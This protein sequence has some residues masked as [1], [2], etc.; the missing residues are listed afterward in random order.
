M[1]PNS[2]VKKFLKYYQ[3]GIGFIAILTLGTIFYFWKLGFIDGSRSSTLYKANFIYNGL[4]EKSHFVEVA[5]LVEREKS[6]KALDQIEE[7]EKELEVVN[8]QIPVKSFEK[9]KTSN[10]NLKTSIANLL[11]FSDSTKVLNVFNLKLKKFNLYVERKEWRTLTRMSERILSKSNRY[12]ER[13]KI[14]ELVRYIEKDFTEMT[15]LTENSVLSRQEK[16][17]ILSRI[18]NLNVEIGML[19]KYF[20]EYQSFLGVLKESKGAL[21]NWLKE[22]A[23]KITFQR[24]QAEQVG[25]YYILGLISILGI[26]SLFFI[27]TFS[28][29]R[30]ILKQEQIAVEKEFETLLKTHIFQNQDLNDNK[31]SEEFIAFIDSISLL[32][33]EKTEIGKAVELGAPF[34]MMLL[35]ENLK[36]EWMNKSAKNIWKVQRSEASGLS[37]DYFNKLTNITGEDPV[38]RLSRENNSGHLP[39]KIKAEDNVTD[40]QLYVSPMDLLGEKKTL[41][42]LNSLDYIDQTLKEQNAEVLYPISSA[43][44]ELFEG[45]F[46]PSE[47]SY[48]KFELNGSEDI[49]NSISHLKEQKITI[50]R[51]MNSLKNSNSMLEERLADIN[52]I[53]KELLLSL[54]NFKNVITESVACNHH[55]KSLLDS[56]CEQLTNFYSNFQT[57]H[58]HTETL[59][60]IVEETKCIVEGL[61]ELKPAIKSGRK[62]LESVASS[63]YSPE[64]KKS[65][66]TVDHVLSKLELVFSS[67]ISQMDAIKMVHKKID[68]DSGYRGIQSY[69]DSINKYQVD[70]IEEKVITGVHSVF[71][72]VKRA[73][74]SLNLIPQKSDQGQ[75]QNYIN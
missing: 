59:L 72:D 21:N 15:K 33:K 22:I 39:I 24:Y 56:L 58:N 35:D 65:L 11:S 10:Q 55:Q 38:A 45:T 44:E 8:E 57:Q 70:D 25:K 6:K 4:S 60:N 27:A 75:D 32:V 54:K 52:K 66:A 37:W 18:S 9:L 36:V 41:L 28:L 29:N 34:G 42:V 63:Q 62:Q 71:L 12:I 50:E 43:L 46:T 53:N 30:K 26:I 31:Y 5:K 3:Y 17:E 73:K 68:F 49:Y 69:Q 61:S 23:P 67:A 2:T 7:I 1:C 13:D 20:V 48:S 64:L 19:N 16:S 47:E 51:E 40:F 74:Q 14:K